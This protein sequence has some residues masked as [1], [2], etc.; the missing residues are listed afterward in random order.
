[1][2]ARNLDSCVCVL[3]VTSPG[4]KEQLFKLPPP[5]RA[6]PPLKGGTVV[7]ATQDMSLSARDPHW[8]SS[9]SLGERVNLTTG[10]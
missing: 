6:L 2:G 1:M 10:S 9:D 8:D 3:K 4:K 7:C 5:T